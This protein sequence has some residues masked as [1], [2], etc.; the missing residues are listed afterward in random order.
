M[1]NRG[2]HRGADEINLI[3]LSILLPTEESAMAL[4]KEIGA[5]LE[6]LGKLWKK[7]SNTYDWEEQRKMQAVI[8][9]RQAQLEALMAELE[10]KQVMLRVFRHIVG[11]KAI[12]VVDEFSAPALQMK[13][14][15]PEALLL[16]EIE[17]DIPLTYA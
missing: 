13:L 9:E 12:V 5:A 4:Q 1:R 17:A 8:A 2:L 15:H 3:K 10:R 7:L 16:H 11:N 6:G 14:S